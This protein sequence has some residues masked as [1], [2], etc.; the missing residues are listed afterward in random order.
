MTEQQTELMT[1]YGIT[2]EHKSVFTYKSYKYSR[3]DDAL[4][5]AK[6]EAKRTAA[7]ALKP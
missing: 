5:Y 7:A 2:E 4:N 6:L 3:L 1:L